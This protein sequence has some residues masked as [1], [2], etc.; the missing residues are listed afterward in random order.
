MKGKKVEDL[1]PFMEIQ[2]T[3]YDLGI[4]FKD[5]RLLGGI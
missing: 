5:S 2:I 1:P 4:T 3:N